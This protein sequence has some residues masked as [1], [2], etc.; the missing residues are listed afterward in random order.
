M[1][2]LILA[3][4]PLIEIVGNE[5]RRYLRE[6]L[7]LNIPVYSW[8]CSR[9][10]S[11][12]EQ[13]MS[14]TK[15][16]SSNNEALVNPNALINYISGPYSPNGIYV[17]SDFH[18]F[19]QNSQIVRNLKDT[20]LELKDYGGK[21][22][23][24]ISPYQVLPPEL[25][26]EAIVIDYPLPD[27]K[28]IY[29][30]VSEILKTLYNLK[31]ISIPKEKAV[32]LIQ[33]V[34]G[35]SLVEIDDAI[36]HTVIETGTIR[37]DYILQEKRRLINK[38]G[39]L[40]C[41][42]VDNAVGLN[43]IGGFGAC[44]KWLQKRMRLFLNNNYNQENAE[45]LVIEADAYKIPL[46]K[47]ILLL[48]IQGGGKSQLAKAVAA[49]WKLP[50]VSL[51]LGKIL[52]SLV[53]ESES[54]MRFALKT[55]ESIQPCVMFIDEIEKGFSGLQSS[56]FSDGGTTAR[57]IG[58]FL[59]W[60]QERTSRIFIIATSNSIENLP[61]ELIRKGRFDEIFFVDLPGKKEREAIW[62][63]HLSSHN[64]NHLLDTTELFAQ[65]SDGFSGAEIESVII[66]LLYD[67]FAVQKQISK[68]NVL[69]KI[70]KTI[71]LSVTH[72]EKI[73]YLRKWALGRCINV[74]D[75]EET[76]VDNGKRLVCEKINDPLSVS[77]V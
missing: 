29:A 10:L 7:N 65:Y 62:R 14:F 61:S 58:Y 37:T 12:V 46:P 66:D 51:D 54:R 20:A 75:S 11:K 77:G 3:Q 27:T 28:E 15:D 5:E 71:P 43:G 36:S 63:I 50:L 69:M 45:K 32:E 40:S 19:F 6:I 55:A 26:K 1:K 9:G 31:K 74:N 13:D 57:V 64:L 53:G 42:N 23:I 47:G 16:D 21:N 39:V 34:K 25:E 38:S 56:S 67:S 22:I 48:G 33:C 49:E 30:H 59:T 18:Q 70:R 17:L 68:E 4:N 76:P 73:D 44:K 2:T 35:L 8:T 52:A 60:L 72:R 41:A 24:L